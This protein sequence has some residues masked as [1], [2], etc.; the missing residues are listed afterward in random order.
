MHEESIEVEEVAQAGEQA[1]LTR[2]ITNWPQRK[3]KRISLK[4]EPLN[5]TRLG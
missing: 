2:V 1:E 5:R 4:V 3:P